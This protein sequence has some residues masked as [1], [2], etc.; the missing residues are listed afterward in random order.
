MSKIPLHL[1]ISRLRRLKLDDQLDLLV[2]LV[3]AEKPYSVR[4]NELMSLLQG[5]RHKQIKRDTKLSQ[6]A[7]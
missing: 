1:I 5:K 4:R 2:K 7:A 3:A 6:K